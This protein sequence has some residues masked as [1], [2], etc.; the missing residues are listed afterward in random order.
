ME[1]VSHHREETATIQKY[2]R[3][4]NLF[5][6]TPKPYGN[7]F[8]HSLHVD[9]SYDV[10][11]V[12]LPAGISLFSFLCCLY[13]MFSKLLASHVT[14]AVSIAGMV[15]FFGVYVVGVA[16]DS[17]DV[18]G[19]S[20]NLFSSSSFVHIALTYPK[21]LSFITDCVTL[22]KLRQHDVVSPNTTEYNRNSARSLSMQLS[23]PSFWTSRRSRVFPSTSRRSSFVPRGSARR[24]G[25]SFP[26]WNNSRRFWK[27]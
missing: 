5:R 4:S 24:I 9:S 23:T 15:S 1:G 18:S 26:P 25:P 16:Y 7:A 22:S 2:L 13:L 19:G 20:C 3:F 8:L 21:R 17:N 6:W 11:F 10:V 14:S 27:S 12:L